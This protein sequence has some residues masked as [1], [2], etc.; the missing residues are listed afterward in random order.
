MYLL[1]AL[2]YSQRI[3]VVPAWNFGRNP[4]I[5]R[6]WDL[7]MFHCGTLQGAEYQHAVG[8]CST[9]ELSQSLHRVASSI[10]AELPPWNYIASGCLPCAM[11][12]VLLLFHGGTFVSVFCGLC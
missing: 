10:S 12:N 4:A 5:R 8:N 3:V 11:L 7:L 2:V 9:M 1:G 6:R